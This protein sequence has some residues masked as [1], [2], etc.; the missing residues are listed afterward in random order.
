[1]TTLVKVYS[2]NTFYRLVEEAV[3]S[4]NTNELEKYLGLEEGEKIDLFELEVL[5]EEKNK[6]E[7]NEEDEEDEDFN[8]HWWL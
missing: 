8:R 6:E 1:M 3:E 5:L 7:E 2:K 4:G